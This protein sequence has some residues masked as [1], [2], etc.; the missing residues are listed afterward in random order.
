MWVFSLQMV[1]FAL[2]FI[3]RFS[4]FFYVTNKPYSNPR[5]KSS[6]FIEKSQEELMSYLLLTKLFAGKKTIT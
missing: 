4:F 5:K 1:S 3:T 6:Y 2:Y